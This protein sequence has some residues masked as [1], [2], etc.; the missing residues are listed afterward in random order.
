MKAKTK[1]RTKR[2]ATSRRS[3]LGK[4]SREPNTNIENRD[5]NTDEQDQITNIDKDDD[6]A[7]PN[8]RDPRNPEFDVEAEEERE[9][10]RKAEYLHPEQ[11]MK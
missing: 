6:L 8:Q 2:T 10:R 3:R 4:N 5:L 7:L 9:K 1:T 11:P